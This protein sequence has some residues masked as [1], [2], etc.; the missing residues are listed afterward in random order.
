[1]RFWS[2]HHKCSLPD[3]NLNAVLLTGETM[4][5]VLL[6]FDEKVRLADAACSVQWLSDCILSVILLQIRVPERQYREYLPNALRLHFV[7]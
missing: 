4:R 1:M 6:Y 2:L 3:H 5:M 7:G